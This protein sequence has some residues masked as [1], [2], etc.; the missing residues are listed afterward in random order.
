MTNPTKCATFF[1]VRRLS[2]RF[3][4]GGMWRAKYRDAVQDVSF[5]VARGEIVAL[6]GESGSGKSTVARTCVRLEEPSGGQILLDGR[7][8][9]HDEPRATLAY[10]KRV[11]MIFQDPFGSLNPMRTVG[12][13]L[14]RPLLLHRGPFSPDELR[15]NVAVLLETVGLI[16]AKDFV[17]KRPGELSGG[18]RQR[19]AIARALAPEPE[20]IFADEPV[21][22]L[23]LSIRADILN[24][25]LD[26]ERSRNLAF[27]YITHDLASARYVADRILVMYAGRVVESGPID[28]VLREPLHPYTKLLAAAVPDIQ[29]PRPS[30][31]PVRAAATNHALRTRGCPFAPRC[32][33]AL[34]PCAQEKPPEVLMNG[35]RLVHCHGL[36]RTTQSAVAAKDTR[37]T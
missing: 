34:E 3:R 14:E 25:M 28:D 13:H 37:P 24:L 10:R 16:P 17:D 12:E 7:D 36:T 4:V 26:L 22:M 29:E 19:V 23:D 32:P 2:K 33:D 30:S 6:V 9:L 35:S 27:V 1:E 21:S 5:T 8:V 11:Q 15:T 31:L 18:Q 20:I